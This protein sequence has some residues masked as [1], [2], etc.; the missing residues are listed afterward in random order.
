VL[1]LFF[2][3]HTFRKL[4]VSK[5]A[6]LPLE[7][8]TVL[9]ALA[10]IEAATRECK[11]RDIETAEVR[12]ALDLLEPHIQP[13]WLIPQF[14]HHAKDW[15]DNYVEREGQQQVLRATFPGIRDAVRELVGRKMDALV[16][17]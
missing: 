14:R 13:A 4:D 1:S 10:V 7:T 9:E 17:K 3:R 11:Q 2:T 16:L 6:V 15:S 8:M 5:C 12:A